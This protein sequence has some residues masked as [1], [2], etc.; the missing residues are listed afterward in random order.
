MPTSIP[1]STS[2]RASLLSSKSASQRLDMTGLVPIALFSGIGLL[3][4]L[5]AILCGVQGGW[6]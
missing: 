6:F 2:A 3:I 1:V 5:V 4:S